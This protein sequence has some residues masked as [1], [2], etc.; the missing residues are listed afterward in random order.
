V[1]AWI[2]ILALGLLG[3]SLFNLARAVWASLDEL[4]LYR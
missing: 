2:F 3:A 4:E 1:V